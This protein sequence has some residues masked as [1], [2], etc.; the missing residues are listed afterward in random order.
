MLLAT[1]QPNRWSWHRRERRVQC[2]H[3]RVRCTLSA[4][5]ATPRERIRTW[6]RSHRPPR[7][8][9]IGRHP[10]VA[11]SKWTP[12]PSEPG[13]PSERPDDRR[14]RSLTVNAARKWRSSVTGSRTFPVAPRQHSP[15]APPGTAAAATTASSRSDRGCR[16]HHSTVEAGPIA[17]SGDSTDRGARRGRAGDE[18]DWL[19]TP[20]PRRAARLDEY[21]RKARA[22]PRGARV[23]LASTFWRSS[24]Q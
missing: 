9:V 5:A 7:W 6:P 8:R 2:L 20:Y 4:R 21:A 11:A 10:R 1:G 13:Y 17:M 22:L 18:I 14:W 24:P 3:R 12:R 15:T 23:E 19:L 16:R